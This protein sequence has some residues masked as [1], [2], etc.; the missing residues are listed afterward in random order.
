M[1]LECMCHKYA[2]IWPW[3]LGSCLG[4]FN[5]VINL[6]QLNKESTE[7]YIFLMANADRRAVSFTLAE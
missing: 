7:C 1:Q 6:Y 3:I 2:Y 5:A 4:F